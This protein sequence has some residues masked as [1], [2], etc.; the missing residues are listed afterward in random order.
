MGR[1]NGRKSPHHTLH[2]PRVCA[3]VCVRLRCQNAADLSPLW[4]ESALHT[5]HSYLSCSERV[6]DNLS[7]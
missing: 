5:L 7:L 4:Q 2:P 3:R 6:T 1:L